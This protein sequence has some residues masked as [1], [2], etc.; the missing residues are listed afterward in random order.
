MSSASGQEE[1]TWRRRRRRYGEGVTT[2]LK[3]ESGRP[4]AAHAPRMKITQ[5][6]GKRR[7]T[8]SPG[9]GRPAS[10]EPLYEGGRDSPAMSVTA[11]SVPSDGMEGAHDGGRRGKH[12]LGVKPALLEALSGNPVGPRLS[13]PAPRRS[14]SRRD[15]IGRQRR[16]S[17]RGAG[18]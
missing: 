11:V 13:L 2:V 15:P 14:L 3:P 9:L 1:G 7:R 10:T 17:N 16:V 5:P 8:C 6:G 12:R 4:A 18:R